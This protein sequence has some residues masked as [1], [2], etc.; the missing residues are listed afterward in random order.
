MLYSRG[1]RTVSGI[2]TAARKGFTMKFS[3]MKRKGKADEAG[4]DEEINLDL[5]I[6]ESPESMPMD[7]ELGSNLAAT[8]AAEMVRELKARG[9]LPADFEEPEE[10]VMPEEM[11]EEEGMEIEVEA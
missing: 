3:D 4:M 1:V 7:M 6:E 2:L 8:S 9:I 11:P 10:D 5:G